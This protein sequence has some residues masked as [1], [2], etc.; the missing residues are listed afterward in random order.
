MRSLC[1]RFSLLL[2]TVGVFACA[3]GPKFIPQDFLQEQAAAQFTEMKRSGRVSDDPKYNAQV[4]RVGAQLANALG[5][6][7]PQANWEYVVFKDDSVNAFAMPGGKIGVHT[8]L[9]DLVSS[10]DE[11]AAVLGHEIAHVTLEHANQR[12]SAEVL[13]AVG[14]F[15]VAY[16]T[17]NEDEETQNLL[18]TAY[19]LG[20]QVGIMLPYSRSHELQSDELGLKYAARAGYN[21]E[22]AL[23][24]WSKMEQASGGGAP[25][26]FLS[27]HPGYNNRLERLRDAMPEAMEIYQKARGRPLD[28]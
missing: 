12:M 14:M 23:Q 17:R 11:L 24:F 15:G 13:R 19:G 9:L 6:D 27:T 8:G 18:M 1:R 25:P 10:D 7:L 4:R 21:P 16:G 22:A 5:S 28:Q 2:L 26:E 20:T 3:S